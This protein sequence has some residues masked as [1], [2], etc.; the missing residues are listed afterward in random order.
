MTLRTKTLTGVA[1]LTLGAAAWT[2]AYAQTRTVTVPIGEPGVSVPAPADNGTTITVTDGEATVETVPSQTGTAEP[3]AGT[4]ASPVDPVADDA[5]DAEA[6]TVESNDSAA[7][8]DGLPEAA[9]ARADAPAEDAAAEAVDDPDAAEPAETAPDETGDMAQDESATAEAETDVDAETAA[10]TDVELAPEAA[11]TDETAAAE[12]VDP[13]SAEV[14]SEDPGEAEMAETEAEDQQAAGDPAEAEPEVVESAHVADVA[15]SFEGPFGKF[16]QFQLQRGL[17]V[18]TEVCSACHGMK[19]VPIRTLSDP[20]GPELPEDQVRA[21]AAQFDIDDPEIDDSRPRIPTD[22][23]PTVEGEGMGP[24]L[25]LLAKS[26]AGFHGPYGTGIRQLFQGIG[27]PE[28][29]HALLT[30]YDDE[31]KEQSGAVFYHNT[32]FP[33]GWISMPPPLSDDLLEYEDGTAATVDQMSLDVAA[34]MMW[35]AEPH[36]MDRKKVGFVSVIF[37][38]VLTA[39][40]YLTNKRLWWDVKHRER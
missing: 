30:G 4:Q 17:Q 21:Y 25:S 27:G 33:S 36:M 31:T 5:P 16:D 11:E 40:L 18:Y 39:L 35:T 32:A 23:L 37:L 14:A 10:E 34:F 38:I 9:D 20:G 15:F 29:I 12:D 8:V 6:E 2:T 1:A 22:H 3:T 26:R 7:S 24:D 19:Q 13:G 28:Y